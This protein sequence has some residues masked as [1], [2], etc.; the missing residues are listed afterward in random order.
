MV[1]SNMCIQRTL[2]ILSI[3]AI[4]SLSSCIKSIDLSKYPSDNIIEEGIEEIL[5]ETT[6]IDVDL[7][8]FS[9]EN[10]QDGKDLNMQADCEEQ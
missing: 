10:P 2:S 9:S 4:F 5:K 1:R 6:S 7:S 3:A 8:P